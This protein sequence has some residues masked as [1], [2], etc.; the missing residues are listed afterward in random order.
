MASISFSWIK[1]YV[2]TMDMR[3]EYCGTFLLGCGLS[4]ALLIPIVIGAGKVTVPMVFIIC[5]ISITS[6]ILGTDISA[7]VKLRPVNGFNSAFRIIVG[8]SALSLLHLVI[9]V[10]TYTSGQQA[11]IIDIFVIAIL[12]FYLQKGH[13]ERVNYIDCNSTGRLLIIDLS[14][15]LMISVFTTLWVHETIV[16]ERYAYDSGLF[17]AWVDFFLHASEIT[18]L[19]DY[20]S[21]G[22]QSLYL[23]GYA[24]PLYHRASY[25]LPAI[26]SFV[27]GQSSL[28]SATFFWLPVGIILFGYGVYG[29]GCTL[30]GRFAGYASMLAVFTLPDGSMYGV[31]NGFFGFH[32][33]L[34]ISPSSGYALAII[35]IALG[36]Y[37]IECRRFKPV[38]W[39]LIGVLMLITT[40]FRVHLAILSI[41]MFVMLGLLTWR[42]TKASHSV[43][44]LFVCS[45]LG[46]ILIYILEGIPFAPHFITG[47][48]RTSELF[49]LVHSHAPPEYF[50]TDKRLT[51]NSNQITIIIIGYLLLLYS[52]LGVILPLMFIV[53]GLSTRFNSGWRIN[54]VPF[55]LIVSYFIMIN[56]MPSPDYFGKTEYLHRPFLLVYSVS[57]SMLT[58]WILDLCNIYISIPCKYIQSNYFIIITTIFSIIIIWKL[59]NNIQ[60]SNLPWGLNLANTPISKGIFNAARYIRI[61]SLPGERVFSSDED[62]L[63]I[64]VALTERQAFLSRKDSYQN[65]QNDA[66]AI[67]AQNS[68]I[69]LPLKNLESLDQLI[70]FGKLSKSRWYLT[71]INEITHLNQYIQNNIVYRSGDIIVFDLNVNSIED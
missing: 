28:A 64:V 11:I 30:A 59:S 14:V 48:V 69:A 16:S 3:Q 29:F 32:W 61:H 13:K 19:R 23:S 66:G 24:Q 50:E 37:V 31:R 54:Y 35:F 36:L 4:V 70:N 60:Q 62:P 39:Y 43:V 9:T 67:Y 34:Q 56:V 63:A 47:K 57:L 40:A 41:I 52:S 45:V 10:V 17:H 21:F 65:M 15:L 33:L 26:F 22:H 38:P 18:Y 8:F 53:A 1:S 58:V 27:S 5:A 68:S 46:F 44:I 51:E 71:R 49:S 6:I 25:A 42:P 7:M 55:I 2:P 12:H 20:S